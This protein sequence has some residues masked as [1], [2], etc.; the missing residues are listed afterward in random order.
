MSSFVGVPSFATTHEGR[1]HL[2]TVHPVHEFPFGS[3]AISG[4]S[5]AT[6]RSTRPS[7]ETVSSKI[8]FSSDVLLCRPCSKDRLDLVRTWVFTARSPVIQ[9]AAVW[10]LILFAR[11]STRRILEADWAPAAVFQLY[12]LWIGCHEAPRGFKRE[13]FNSISYCIKSF[14]RVHQ[15]RMKYPVDTEKCNAYSFCMLIFKK[16]FGWNTDQWWITSF[17]LLLL[18]I[19]IIVLISWSS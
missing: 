7:D 14:E 16:N 19:R 11:R 12:Q 10:R 2:D 15:K 8:L 13:H 18:N 3:E 1:T 4:L 17:L 6:R 9:M 5:I